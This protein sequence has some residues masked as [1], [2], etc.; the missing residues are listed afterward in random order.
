MILIGQ[1]SQL[2]SC[3]QVLSRQFSLMHQQPHQAERLQWSRQPSQLLLRRI[4]HFLKFLIKLS[5]VVPPQG[6]VGFHVKP[7]RISLNRP[8]IGSIPVLDETVLPFEWGR[9]LS[10]IA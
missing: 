2:Q 8:R 1:S 9:N 3:L 7:C 6:L 4:R 10:V 5:I